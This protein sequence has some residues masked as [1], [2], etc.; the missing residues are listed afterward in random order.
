MK[1]PATRQKS[2]AHGTQDDR[3]SHVHVDASSI[4]P[5]DFFDPDPK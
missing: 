1:A 5:I 3:A 2:A 4:R